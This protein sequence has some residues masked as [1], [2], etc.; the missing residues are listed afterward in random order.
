M[1]SLTKP[2]SLKEIVYPVFK[3]GSERPLFEEG[4]VLFV[5]VG[6]SDDSITYY[7]VDDTTLDGNT[8][9]ERRISLLRQGVKLKKLTR[10]VFFLGDLVKVATSSTWFIDSNGSVFRY[11]KRTSVKLT[12]KKIKK[13]IPIKTGGAIIEVEGIPNRFKCLYMPSKSKSYAGVL[14]YNMS[15]IL[16]DLADIKYDDTRRKI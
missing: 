9:A 4:V 7:I 6:R 2:I 8:L 11:S 16:Y 15:Y 5:H 14:F 10:A 12:Y 1:E 3:I 13:V